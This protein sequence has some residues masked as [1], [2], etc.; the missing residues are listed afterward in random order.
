MFSNINICS[1][2]S[3]QTKVILICKSCFL[4]K[5]W[6]L[7]SHVNHFLV[8]SHCKAGPL[9]RRPQAVRLRASPGGTLEGRSA[10]TASYF[11]KKSPLFNVVINIITSFV[12]STTTVNLVKCASWTST[13]SASA[14]QSWWP[15]PQALHCASPHG[16]NRVFTSLIGVLDGY[17]GNGDA[18]C[19]KSLFFLFI[20][21]P[22]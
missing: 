7:L 3:L 4:G 8:S 18:F 19:V 9:V 6:K 17:F 12:E 21:Y 11:G 14:Q 2:E 10:E 5:N 16:W 1:Y 20:I 15:T 13:W 22:F